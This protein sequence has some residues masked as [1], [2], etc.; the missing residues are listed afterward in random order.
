M[1]HD[2]RDIVDIAE[3][4]FDDDL[5]SKRESININEQYLQTFQEIQET[6]Y[7]EI[8]VM[9]ENNLLIGCY[10]IM[11]LPHFSFQGTKRAQVES[12]RIK[13]QYRAQGFGTKLMK[14]AMKKAKENG[15]GIFQ[16]T[17]NKTRDEA[18]MFYSKLGM[19]STHN[20]F[21][22]YFD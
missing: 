9:E 14:H 20:G 7:F 15:C 5:G 4:L 19:S 13:S 11:Y 8:Y 22:I 2:E 21:K 1:G 10:Q 18:N 12:I 16:L 3:L 6:K 17:T